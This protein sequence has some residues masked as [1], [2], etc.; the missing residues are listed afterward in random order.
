MHGE[1]FFTLLVPKGVPT[2]LPKNVMAETLHGGM[3]VRDS[4]SVVMVVT[5]GLIE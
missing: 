5:P 2:N 1:V 4:A 3:R